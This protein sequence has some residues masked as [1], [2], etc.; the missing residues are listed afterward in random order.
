MYSINFIFG[1]IEMI[2][3]KEALSQSMADMLKAD[4]NRP[5]IGEFIVGD[6]IRGCIVKGSLSSRWLTI[7]SKVD[8]D[9][10]HQLQKKKPGYVPTEYHPHSRPLGVQLIL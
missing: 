8:I 6:I 2:A 9:N 7:W 4:K 3:S 5:H 1:T 10:L